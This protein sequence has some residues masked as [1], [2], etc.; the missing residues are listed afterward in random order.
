MQGSHLDGAAQIL[1]AD[2][3]TINVASGHAL[4]SHSGNGLTA[5]YYALV[6]T[7]VGMLAANV[8][9]SQSTPPWATYMPT[10]ARSASATRCATP[11]VRI[12][13]SSASS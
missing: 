2:P 13:C 4:G 10:S 5:F 3:V 9:I 7:V 12:P 1:L 8:V 6:L 11:A